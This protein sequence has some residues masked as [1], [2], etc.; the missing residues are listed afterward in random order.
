MGEAPLVRRLSRSEADASPVRKADVFPS[1]GAVIME[2]IPYALSGADTGQ[3]PRP[4]AVWACPREGPGSGVFHAYGAAAPRGGSRCMRVP[5]FFCGIPRMRSASLHPGDLSL[6]ALF[7]DPFTVQSKTGRFFSRR[8]GT[9]K[10][11]FFDF[12]IC[13]IV[14]L[15][16]S[17]KRLAFFL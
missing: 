5:P 9:C 4:L 1:P 15:L 8:P 16:R 14:F 11:A 2:E 3:I 12:P 7:L 6:C 17:G 10:G 13:L